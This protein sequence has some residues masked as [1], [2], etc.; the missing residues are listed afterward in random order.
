MSWRLRIPFKIGLYIEESLLV[1]FLLLDLLGFLSLLPPD[2]EFFDKIIAWSLMAL[3]LYS[4]KLSKVFFGVRDKQFDTWLIVSYFLFVIKDMLLVIY[5]VSLHDPYYAPLYN[6]I[7][8]HAGEIQFGS[9]VLGAISLLAISIYA[10]RY[11]PIRK[12]SLLNVIGE[13][14]ATTN[15]WKK[16]WRY[17]R[18][19]FVL[20]A[21]FVIVF[22]L[23]IEWI[24]LLE[25]D[26]IAIASIALLIH[27]VLRLRQKKKTINKHTLLFTI[28]EPI[29]KF[30]V[31]FIK[32]LQSKEKVFLVLSGMLIMHLLTDILVFIVPLIFGGNVPDFSTPGVL[33]TSMVELIKSDLTHTLLYALNIF[34][35]VALMI[36]PAIIWY[37]IY[38]ERKERVPIWLTLPFLIS[39]ATFYFSP[40]FVI[41]SIVSLNFIGVDIGTQAITGNLWVPFVSA[42]VL[43]LIRILSDDYH[44]ER[45]F[46]FTALFGMFYFF[47]SYFILY[48]KSLF[49]YY[50]TIIP[51]LPPFISGYFTLFALI[52]FAFYSAGI[53][54]FI[55]ASEEEFDFL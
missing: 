49:F 30:Y 46:L 6:L 48:L 39:L 8:Q 52:T 9:F 26:I 17:V 34:A 25:D 54:Y 42:A 40:A 35:I 24:A 32:L 18:I 47:A 28:G 3:L 55:L 50:I 43:L 11:I 23:A 33:H 44:S 7:I 36:A 37:L 31:K 21:F 5:E 41:K 10:T 12:P 14:G 38:T 53:F 45:I 29:E 16:T 51:K 4:A 2:I 20:N 27:V 15:E 1:L 19:F 13:E 22:N